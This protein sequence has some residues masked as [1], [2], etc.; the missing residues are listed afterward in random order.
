[1]SSC[2]IIIPVWNQLEATKECIASIRRNTLYPYRLVIVDNASDQST[3]EFLLDLKEN[4]DLNL[5]LIRNK[6]NEGFIKAVNKGVSECSADYIC[7]LNNDTVVAKGWLGE[8]VNVINTDPAIGIVN[9]SSNSLGQ[10]LPESIKL[11][12]FVSD[13][14]GSFVKVGTALGFCMLTR[15][16]LFEEIGTFD[17]AFGM[18]Y[19]E[20][21]DFSRRAMEKGYNLVRCVASYVYHK[22]RNSFK[23]IKSFNH[24]FEKN[25]KLFETK[26]GKPKRITYIARDLDDI[27]LKHLN[28]LVASNI[29]K[30]YWTYVFSVSPRANELFSRFSNV[31]VYNFKNFFWLSSFL[32]VLFK[33]KK[34]ET[35]YCDNKAL[36]GV[37]EIFK[38]IHRANVRGIDA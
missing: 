24:D 9:P 12:D 7:I 8:L 5:K 11:D 2:D 34:T 23:K 1:M 30:G 3:T 10:V 15:K 14:K 27:S 33:K 6:E 28:D 25:R 35:I 13:Q 29:Q 36:R 18:G 21:T 16:K 17:E 26:W 31:T 37:L 38:P 20:D 4:Q 19:F 22:E 32:K